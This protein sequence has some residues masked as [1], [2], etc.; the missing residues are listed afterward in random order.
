M[1]RTAVTIILAGLAGAAVDGAY[2]SLMGL[3]RGIGV[4]RVWQSVAGG[5]IGAAAREGG[6]A[7]ALL[8]FATHI[9]IALVMAAVFMLALSRIGL[10]RRRRWQ[11]A[12][13]YGLG[14]YLVMYLLVLPLR[15]PG[16][17][18]RWDGLFSIADIAAHIGVALAIAAIIRWRERA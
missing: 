12:I 5:W 10:L 6:I 17:F 11:A 7:T 8:G 15:W 3:I 16:I 14:L 4:M 18:P 13:A 9:G 1:R 2:A